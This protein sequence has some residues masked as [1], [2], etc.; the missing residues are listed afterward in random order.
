MMLGTLLG[1]SAIAVCT[2]TTE[3]LYDNILR[4]NKGEKNLHQK[5]SFAGVW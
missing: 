2:L 3:L 1:S 5:Y 4:K